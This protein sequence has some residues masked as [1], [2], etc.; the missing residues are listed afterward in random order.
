M[1]TVVYLSNQTVQIVTGNPG[2]NKIVINECYMAEA[3]DG[4]I[5]NGMIMD[6]ELF[7]GFMRD[8]WQQY[9]LAKKNVILV[10]DSTKFIGKNIEVPVMNNK[11]TGEFIEREFSDVRKDDEYLYGYIQ[12]NAENKMRKLYVEAIYPEFVKDFI[13]IFDEM[14]VK[15]SA[16]YSGESSLIGLISITLGRK[17]G[18]FILQVAGKMTITTLLFVNGSFYY[19]N[20]SRCFHEQGSLDYANDIA[21]SVSQITQFM[22]A[23]QI[24]YP[25]ET[26]CLA[27]IQPEAFPLYRE[28][29][30]AQGVSA[31]IEIFSD[32]SILSTAEIDVQNTLHS[33]SG[34]VLYD[35]NMNFYSI[36]SSNAKKDKNKKSI[37]ATKNII[38]IAITC[39]VMLLG[40]GASIA[41]KTI[42]KNELSKLTDFNESLDTIMNVAKYDALVQRNG[43]LESQYS[44]I[45]DIDENLLTYPLGNDNVRKCIF[46]CATGY[47]EIKFESFNADEGTIGFTARAQSVDNINLFIKKLM[48]QSIF[49]DIRYTGYTYQETDGKWDIHVE[50]VLSE[51]AGR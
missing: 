43:F 19:F 7:A 36:Y 12:L 32:G 29:I 25:L 3:P 8:L 26:I 4:S 9:N 37:V 47:A 27:G 5:I 40:L 31:N 45:S 39:A 2:K 21:R 22:Q 24:E 34:L 10:V 15:L 48:E 42:K 50:C 20:S 44:A 16:I 17:Y 11:A 23:H 46:G 51:A 6:T 33:A 28:A 14:G 35:K 30:Y 49:S 38:A 1:N 41:V 18:T 13:D